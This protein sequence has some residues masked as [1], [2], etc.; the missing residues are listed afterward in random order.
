MADRENYSRARSRREGEA[1]PTNL[2]HK[3]FPINVCPGNV[4]VILIKIFFIYRIK[5]I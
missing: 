5:N 1:G 3:V 4:V 2:K